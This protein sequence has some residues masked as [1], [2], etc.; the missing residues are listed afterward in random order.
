MIGMNGDYGTGG[1]VLG[2][3]HRLYIVILRQC[4]MLNEKKKI[5]FT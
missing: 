5:R 2:D 1:Q 3:K 4:S